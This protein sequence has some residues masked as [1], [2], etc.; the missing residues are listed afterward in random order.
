MAIREEKEIKIQI[1]KEEEKLFVCEHDTTL[2]YHQ[3]NY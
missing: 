3:K 2:R 1:G